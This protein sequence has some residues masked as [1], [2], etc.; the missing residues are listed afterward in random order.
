MTDCAG[1]DPLL[2]A[3]GEGGGGLACLL[4]TKD[5]DF[6]QLVGSDLVTYRLFQQAIQ[7][8]LARTTISSSSS[9]NFNNGYPSSGQKRK[10]TTVAQKK[11]AKSD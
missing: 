5:S 8:H 1:K 2:P 10:A 3:G 9:S 11:T 4:T 6:V 7:T